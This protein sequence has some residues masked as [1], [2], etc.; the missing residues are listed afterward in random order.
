[1]VVQRL[2]DI[3]QFELHTSQEGVVGGKD[4]SNCERYGFRINTEHKLYKEILTVELQHLNF[5]YIKNRGINVRPQYNNTCVEL[6]LHLLC[7][8]Y[9]VIIISMTALIMIR[10]TRHG[11][12]V[13]VIHTI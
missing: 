2:L 1:M 4:V 12:K 6:L 9:I 3:F 10:A 8:L 5:N 11:I 7:H 13:I